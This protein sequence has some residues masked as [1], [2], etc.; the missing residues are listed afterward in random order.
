MGCFSYK[1]KKCGKP[2]NS[3]SGDGEHCI[4]FFLENGKV[5]ERMC[6]QYDSYGRVFKEET[7][8]CYTWK[9]SEWSDLVDKHC[10]DDKTSGFAIVHSKCVNR[11]YK[12]NTIS[13]DDPCQ[14]WGKYNSKKQETYS[15]HILGDQVLHDSRMPN[16][17]NDKDVEI[18]ETGFSDD[19][20][21]NFD[22]NIKESLKDLYPVK[23]QIEEFA[24]QKISEHM[25]LTHSSTLENRMN[26]TVF[27]HSVLTELF[28]IF[29][30]K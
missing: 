5:V 16:V 2:V 29:K 10:N 27:I 28:N 13:L 24:W 22:N 26:R 23:K 1:C 8:E 17:N 18:L 11:D 7:D 30:T 6:G 4:I 25:K 21:E 19:E 15:Y 20:Y 14:G 9:T 12:P 3:S